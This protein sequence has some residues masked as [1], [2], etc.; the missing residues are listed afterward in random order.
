MTTIVCNRTSMAAD[1]RI[2]NGP[3]FSTDKLFRVNG[4]IYGVCDNIEHGLK[5]IEWRRN[6]DNK[7]TFESTTFCA[8]E[9][10]GDGRI[11]WWGPDFVA[12]P[13]HEEFYG[14][15][16]GAELAP[17][18]AYAARGGWLSG[19]DAKVITYHRQFGEVGRVTIN[20]KMLE[21]A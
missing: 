15:G 14:I 6:T 8:L 16:S 4:S 5:F 20:S 11:Y 1:R 13:V 21:S 12:V 7:P 2:T 10:T 17:A 18:D 3:M 19:R 9:L